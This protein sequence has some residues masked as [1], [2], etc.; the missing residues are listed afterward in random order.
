MLGKGPLLHLA[1]NF[2]RQFGQLLAVEIIEV[3][4]IIGPQS[5]H[6]KSPVNNR[7]HFNL[8]QHETRG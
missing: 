3:Q 6:S 4:L 7:L 2:G 5:C 1:Y 8:P